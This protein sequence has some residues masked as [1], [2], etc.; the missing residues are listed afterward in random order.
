MRYSPVNL[1][2]CS[3]EKQ[4]ENFFSLRELIEVLLC[5]DGQVYLEFRS[6]FLLKV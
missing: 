3:I 6:L 1:R 5:L 4:G 2:L